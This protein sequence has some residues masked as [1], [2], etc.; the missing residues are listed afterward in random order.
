MVA[1]KAALRGR[2]RAATMAVLSADLKVAKTA[3]SLEMK[4]AEQ[5]AG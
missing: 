5:M 3:E 4:W 2:K 1:M